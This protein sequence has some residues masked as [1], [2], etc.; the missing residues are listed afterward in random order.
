MPKH[1]RQTTKS[2]LLQTD[3][4]ERASVF[5]AR[6]A[7]D[8]DGRRLLREQDHRI[9]FDLTDSDPFRVHIKRGKSGVTTDVAKPEGYDVNDLIHFRLS[10]ATLARLFD[11]KIRF[12]DALIPI[13]QDGSD[14]MLLL[15]CTLFKWSVL[16]WIGRMFRGAQLRGSGQ[17]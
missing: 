17:V 6:L 11:G 7:G 1:R 3:L 9:E 4:P 10:S 8:A 2:R 16:S 14:A 5:F 13:Q 15:E 12:T